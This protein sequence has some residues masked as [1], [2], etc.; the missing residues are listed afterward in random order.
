LSPDGRLACWYRLGPPEGPLPG[1]AQ[2][3]SVPPGTVL[4]AHRVDN[5]VL[6]LD[7][8]VLRAGG[9]G[10]GDD[11]P[12]R[13]RVPVGGAVPVGALTAALVEVLRLPGAGWTLLVNGA[14]VGPDFVLL[15]LGAPGAARLQLRP[16]DPA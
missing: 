13:M 10:R 11:P 5:R 4:V 15:D 7:V 8:E 12:L 3:A 14:V 6:A 16:Q 1:T 2:A 9:E